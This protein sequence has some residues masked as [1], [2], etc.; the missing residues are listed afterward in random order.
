MPRAGLSAVDITWAGAVIV[1]EVG[2]HNLTL[3]QLAERLNVRAPSLYKHV[4]G[5]A[6]VQ[7]RIATLA[8]TELDDAIRDA[9][10]GVAGREALGAL[11]T[12]I[13]TYVAEHPGRYAATIG[14]R[15]AGPDDPLLKASTRVIDSISAVLR[16]YGIA[17]DEIVHAIRAMRC[18]LHG[19]ATLQ[20]TDGFQ[21]SGDAE[22]SFQWLIGFMD[23]GLRPARR[24]VAARA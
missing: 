4:G 8:M 10:R 24:R 6:D 12:A 19:F 3:G 14:A 18:A 13:R 9:I 22:E 2:F 1:D 16:G 21:W 7:H 20:A 17:E 5:L 15:F 11:A 23:R